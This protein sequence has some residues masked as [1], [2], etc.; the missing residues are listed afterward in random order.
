MAVRVRSVRVKKWPNSDRLDKST[1]FGIQ[2]EDT[3]V[4]ILRKGDTSDLDL[5][6][7]FSRSKG[8]ITP[9]YNTS[10]GPYLRARTCV[11]VSAKKKKNCDVN[12]HVIAPC[13]VIGLVNKWP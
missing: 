12:R 4:N 7:Q 6:G 9:I 5:E 1:T 3:K 10:A 2:I 13:P 8:H 11:A